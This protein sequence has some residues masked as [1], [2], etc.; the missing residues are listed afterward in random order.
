MNNFGY[1][2]T[3]SLQM[4]GFILLAEKIIILSRSVII[5]KYVGDSKCLNMEKGKAYISK[6]NYVSTFETIYNIYVGTI[7]S[8][9]GLF[10]TIFDFQSDLSI[11]NKITYSTSL[12]CLFMLITVC[13]KKIIIL[14]L[15]YKYKNNDKIELNNYEV[16]DGT[17]AMEVKEDK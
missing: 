15:K 16:P 13:I 8:F 4:T 12:L 11:L 5:T 6:E 10:M 1:V 17:M 9:I 2:M 14:N 7:L 3:F